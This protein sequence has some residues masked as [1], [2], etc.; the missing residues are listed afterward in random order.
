MIAAI[1]S[2]VDPAVEAENFITL[3][4]EVFT[5]LPNNSGRNDVLCSA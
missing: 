1:E 3:E 4:V 2:S 5:F